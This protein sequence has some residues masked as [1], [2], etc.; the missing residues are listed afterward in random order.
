MHRSGRAERSD[1]RA[2]GQRHFAV[3]AA[4]ASLLEVWPEFAEA[5]NRSNAQ[6]LTPLNK[7]EGE[8]GGGRPSSVSI[9]TPLHS[10]MC[11]FGLC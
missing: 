11:L 5:T 10:F 1:R 4:R 7:G 9:S 3:T 2:R 8:G 6:V